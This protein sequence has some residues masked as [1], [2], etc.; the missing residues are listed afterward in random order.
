MY[1]GCSISPLISPLNPALQ[2]PRLRQLSIDRSHPRLPEAPITQ[3]FHRLHLQMF[4][5]YIY[6]WSHRWPPF[7]DSLSQSLKQWR[8][9]AQRAGSIKAERMSSSEWG[10]HTLS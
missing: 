8:S 3:R 6:P 4:K 9:N 10:I 5:R 2:I 7:R 1:G